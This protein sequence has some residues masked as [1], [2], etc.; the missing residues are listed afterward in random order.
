MALHKHFSYIIWL[1]LLSE[2]L[3]NATNLLTL[4][5]VSL[6][7][8]YL[9][10][11]LLGSQKYWYTCC[12]LTYVQHS[13]C[14][15]RFK[16]FRVVLLKIEVFWDIATLWHSSTSQ[17]MEVFNSQHHFHLLLALFCNWVPR[18]FFFDPKFYY[19]NF[20]QKCQFIML[21]LQHTLILCCTPH[22]DEQQ[23]SDGYYNR[24][25]LRYTS[26]C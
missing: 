25:C 4:F 3:I 26:A 20:V 9:I 5:L 22:C 21:K 1:Y 17:K 24:V 15:V 19:R 16:V 23:R 10:Y 11:T 18:N 12:R 7:F 2:P 14:N 13:S 6:T 8:M